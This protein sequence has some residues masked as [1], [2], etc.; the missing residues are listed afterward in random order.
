MNNRNQ[1]TLDTKITSDQ[2]FGHNNII[3]FEPCRQTQIMIDGFNSHDSWLLNNW[4]T[5]IE[6]N[7]NVLH[8]GDLLFKSRQET[9]KKLNGKIDLIY[10]NHEKQGVKTYNLLNYVYR[11]QVLIYGENYSKNENDP[12][13]SAAIE[14]I[15]GF[16]ILFSHYPVFD[17]N[18][19]DNQKEKIVKRINFLEKLYKEYEC[20]LN[21][22]GHTHSR[23]SKFKNSFNVSI[24]A[25][26]FKILTLKEILQ[27]YY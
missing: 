9:L 10:G 3:R 6:K 5:Q 18:M 23:K 2:H 17:N 20:D 27:L 1:I 12:L 25:T 11:N 8:L 15:D 4:N 24:E 7:D 21:I 19:Y 22:H 26:N 13:L 14:E 16:R